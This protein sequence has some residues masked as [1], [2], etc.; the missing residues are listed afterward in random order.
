[1]WYRI[2]TGFYTFLTVLEI[3]SLI[4]VVVFF[5]TDAALKT[6]H[7]VFAGL[8]FGSHCLRCWC[9]F[10]RRLLAV[11]NPDYRISKGPRAGQRRKIIFIANGL[12]CTL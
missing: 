2:V 12:W 10:I 3:V 5:V 11:H 9:L 6:P 7:Y 8:A 4:L 1:M